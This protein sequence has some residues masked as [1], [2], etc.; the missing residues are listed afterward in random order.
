MKMLLLTIWI[1]RQILFILGGL[2]QIGYLY[3]T[4]IS[5]L[6]NYGLGLLI[7]FSI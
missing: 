3:Y 2:M 4:G 1:Q 5:F 7:S 6:I